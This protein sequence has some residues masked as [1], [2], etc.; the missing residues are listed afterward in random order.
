[1]RSVASNPAFS[2]LENF[3]D[4]A[5][6]ESRID[7][8]QA[9]RP[10]TRIF[11]TASRL[12]LGCA[13]LGSRI[14]K[15]SGLQALERA[16]DSG[17]N[18][19]DL[20]PSYGDGDAEA[21]FG[22]FARS[23]RD[24][25]HI[26][27]KVGMAPTRIHPLMRALKPTAQHVV[28]LF[29]QLRTLAAR[30]RPAPQRLVLNGQLILSSLENSLRRLNTEYL[31]VLA[32]HYLEIDDLERDDVLRALETV[33]TSGKARAVGV[34]GSPDV[35]RLAI[36]QGKPWHIQFAVG[37][38]ARNLSDMAPVMAE[39]PSV[40]GHSIFA[41][42]HALRSQLVLAA[43]ATRDVLANHDYGMDLDIALRSAMLDAALANT[44][45]GVT[46]LS[47]FTPAHLN[48]ALERL[49][50]NDGA[51]AAAFHHDLRRVLA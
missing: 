17:I 22:T 38:F 25:L 26:C 8:T 23:R 10:T 30:G 3:D 14:S 5:A 48:F 2:N 1:M 34:A 39:A 15:S 49:E 41:G 44:P 24:R 13:S 46:V 35:A 45:H 12:G 29:P 20:A 7:H 47:A 4:P 19:F 40:V 9:T 32:L 6:R 11:P 28:S 33:V 27:T 16:L 21:V 42:L 37:A 18:W 50:K 36:E 51:R 43:D 31:D